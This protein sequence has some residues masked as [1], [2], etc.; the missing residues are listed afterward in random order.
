MH[1]VTCSR[2]ESLIVTA[3]LDR[4]LGRNSPRNARHWLLRVYGIDIGQVGICS[5]NSRFKAPQAHVGEF[6]ERLIQALL[7]QRSRS[8]RGWLDRRRPETGSA[9]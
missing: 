6:A 7:A 5:D 3:L 8:T 4:K 1:S 9:V 2:T